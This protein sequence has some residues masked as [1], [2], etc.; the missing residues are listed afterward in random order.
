MRQ[1]E[2]KVF[3]ELLEVIGSK[4]DVLPPEIIL[5]G[6]LGMKGDYAVGELMVVGR[7]VNGWSDGWL[8]VDCKNYDARVSIA[9]ATLESVESPC[10][11]QWV[12]ESWGKESDY[13][14]KKSAFW[15]VMNTL[16]D[17]LKIADIESNK[18]PS[19][20]I[21]S[22][23]YKIAPEEGGNPSE[24]LC[25]IQFDYCVRLL[26]QEFTQWN[27]KKV[28]VLTGINWAMPF[29]EKLGLEFNKSISTEYVD[30][31]CNSNLYGRNLTLVVAKHPQGK[32]ETALVHEVVAEFGRYN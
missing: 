32:N 17:K 10:P 31:S 9:N 8:P 12:S 26:N 20:L 30:G 18:W 23:L 5:T 6:F 7:A 28:L 21:W 11:M 29:L 27:P 4:S 22:N 19:S 25:D 15:R 13:N 3:Q 1:D 24:R 16:T 2:L 14:T